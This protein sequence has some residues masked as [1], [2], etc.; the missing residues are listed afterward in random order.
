[1]VARQAIP[2]RKRAPGPSSRD[3]GSRREDRPETGYRDLRP[4]YDR[5][6]AAPS[7]ST[8]TLEDL[9]R[10]M[11]ALQLARC[12]TPNAERQPPTASYHVRAT[13]PPESDSSGEEPSVPQHAFGLRATQA[14]PIRQV[15]PSY[16]RASTLQGQGGGL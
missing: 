10:A 11:A 4:N 3:S 16:C 12:G 7:T 13:G 9:Q 2:N 8:V 1:M 5:R 14:L 15:T 6:T